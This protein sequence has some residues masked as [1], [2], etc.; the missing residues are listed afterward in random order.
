MNLIGLGGTNG[1]GKDTVAEMLVERRG[2]LF[3][4]LSNLLRDEARSRGQEPG[5]EVL[6]EISAQWRRE[7]GL[8]V[9]V[10]KAIEHFESVK[11]QHEGLVVSSLRHPAEAMVVHE[12]GGRVVWVDADP[13]IRYNRITSRV[14]DAESAHNFEQFMAA[15]Q[16]EMAHHGGDKTTLNMGDVKKLADMT[17]MNDGDDIPA[18]CD[19]AERELIG[20]K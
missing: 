18:F 13:R 3:V 8:G 19:Y 11:D 12:Y 16:A 17:L 15:E 6:R 14:R 2:W 1:A 20:N 7:G 10:E 5:R 4:S 9:L